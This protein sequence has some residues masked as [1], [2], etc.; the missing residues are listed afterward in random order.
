MIKIHLGVKKVCYV[1][2][3]KKRI[4]IVCKALDLFALLVPIRTNLLCNESHTIVEQ[5]EQHYRNNS[6]LGMN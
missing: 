1:I 4:R 5:F 6:K 2:E 3:T